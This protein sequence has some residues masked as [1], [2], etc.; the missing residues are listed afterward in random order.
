[1]HSENSTVAESADF[2]KFPGQLGQLMY[3]YL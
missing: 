3:L 2:C 1:M